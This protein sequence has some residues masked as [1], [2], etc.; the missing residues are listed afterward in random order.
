MP[1]RD[2]FDEPVGRKT[3]PLSNNAVNKIFIPEDNGSILIPST[4]DIEMD[5]K[6]KK[7]QSMMLVDATSTKDSDLSSDSGPENK[8]DK[9]SMQKVAKDVKF[10]EFEEDQDDSSSRGSEARSSSMASQ[11]AD[12]D[13]YESMLDG[14]QTKTLDKGK[15]S[16]KSKRG[17]P[18][19][20]PKAG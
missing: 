1:P 12:D 10:S 7:H 11:V 13:D 17:R 18:T 2:E 14:R 9:P 6:K 4:E 3:K 20:D 8:K 15:T 19:K 16:S 5:M